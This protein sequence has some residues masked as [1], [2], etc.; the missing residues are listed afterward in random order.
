MGNSAPQAGAFKSKTVV[1]VG[2]SYAGFNIAVSL[3]DHFNVIVIDQND[4]MEHIHTNL[5]CSIE[6]NWSD[7]LLHSFDVM[8]KAY[9]GKY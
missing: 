2:F 9:N 6:K 3:W 8:Q 7:E 5:K 4:Y 1:I